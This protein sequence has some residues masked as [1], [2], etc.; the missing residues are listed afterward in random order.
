MDFHR[1][2]NSFVSSIQYQDEGRSQDFEKIKAR[3][4][5]YFQLF[6]ISRGVQKNKNSQHFQTH[7]W[8][9]FRIR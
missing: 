8:T 9:I 1:N 2:N 7:R 6:L 5:L 3:K 4:R